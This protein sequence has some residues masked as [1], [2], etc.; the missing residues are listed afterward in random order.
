VIYGFIQAHPEYAAA[1][2][3][4]FLGIS[5]SGYYEWKKRQDQ[6]QEQ[7]QAYIQLIRK[8]FEEGEGTYGVDRVCGKLREQGHKA[9]YRK[10]Q[11]IMKQEGLRSIHRRQRQKS[12]TDSRKA[13][14]DAYVNL[15]KDLEITKP[16]QVLS[17]DIS[18][19]RTGEG[20]EYLCE[21][22][23]VC[24]GIVLAYS[25]AESM[26]AELVTETIR[27]MMRRWDLPADCICH[28]DRG[29]QYT[30]AAVKQLLNAYQIRQSFSRVGKTGDNAWSESFY[31]NLKKEAVHWRYFPTRMEARQAIFAYIESFY[32]TRRIQKRLGYLS[33]MTW[34]RRWQSRVSTAVA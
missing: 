11:A 32:N 28:N 20:F 22:R 9:S 31:A 19:I 23:D 25:M 12:R 27:K 14:S 15:V 21:I 30:S 24:I 18:Y 2:W 26:K 6:Q 17:S 3:V 34:L 8:I 13:R 5:R 29:S 4:R 7:R 16:F 1:K 33:P 10:V